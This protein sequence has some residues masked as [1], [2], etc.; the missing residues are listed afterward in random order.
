MIN[1][2]WVTRPKRKLDSI[3][4]ILAIVSEECYDNEW[5]G[6]KEKQLLFESKLEEKGLKRKGE[7]R[8]QL[9]GGGR[10]YI[11][12]LESLGLIFK[13][14]KSKKV[15]FTLAGEA[16]LNG[17][18]PVEVMRNQIFKY[19]FPSA[20]TYF[21]RNAKVDLRFKIRPFRFMFKLM[22]DK[23][24]NYLTV[25]EIAKI[26]I[27]EAENES[28][29]CYS[30]IINRILYFRKVGDACLDENFFEKYSSSRAKKIKN[31]SMYLD[32][33]NTM[34]NWMEYTQFI[35]IEKN[36]IMIL[37]SKLEEVKKIIYD[38]SKMI[39]RY[40]NYE[41]F[42]RKYGVD[43]RHKKDTRNLEMT[44]NVTKQMI[45]EARIK[46]IFISK[47][48]KEPIFRITNDLI[49]DISYTSGIKKETVERTLYQFYPHGSMNNFLTGYYN[50]A[51]SG[52]EKA[53]DFEKA[54]TKICNEVFRY[55]ARH[56][57][58]IGLTP[59]VEIISNEENYTGIIDNK[60]YAKYTISNDHFN[61]MVHNYIEKYKGKTPPLLFFLYI[62]GGFSEHIDFQIK[63]I[64]DA[65]GIHGACINVN[66][67]IYLIKKYE[68]GNINHKSLLELF[69]RD[70]EILLNDLETVF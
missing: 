30:Y 39:D 50:M 46:R 5:Q 8:D 64:Y 40:E 52:N 68:T 16:I 65:T 22:L 37:P 66:N 31:F 18:S 38:E 9:A 67:F 47:S 42:Q 61:R 45:E 32:I 15:K 34:K 26:L 20:Y 12:W 25:E 3:P 62:A 27:V 19:Q 60:A 10:T 70:R 48:M 11:A 63:K 53:H 13:Q 59:D 1:Y 44:I 17:T 43:P 6:K 54:T 4:E 7:R 2:W 49:L 29:K 14:K 21:S 23:Q 41:Y 51:F 24:I 58:S 69:T 55:D 57:G 36:K 28:D 35:F 33:A 56:V